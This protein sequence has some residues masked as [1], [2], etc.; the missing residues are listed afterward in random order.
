L[1]VR[2]DRALDDSAVALLAWR[3]GQIERI[4]AK[5]LSGGLSVLWSAGPTGGF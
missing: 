5:E 1:E 2:L 4:D 3:S